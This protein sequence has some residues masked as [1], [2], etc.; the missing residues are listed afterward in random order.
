MLEAQIQIRLKDRLENR[1]ILGIRA[2][3]R[4]RLGARLFL[5]SENLQ[6]CIRASLEVVDKRSAPNVKRRDEITD[7]AGLVD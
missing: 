1:A 5:L 3:V 4:K 2:V 7:R 6:I